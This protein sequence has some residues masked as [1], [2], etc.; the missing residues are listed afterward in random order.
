MIVE[1]YGFSFWRKIK[2]L[3][4]KRKGWGTLMIPLPKET[5]EEE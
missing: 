5:E 2:T 3:K 4:I 1:T